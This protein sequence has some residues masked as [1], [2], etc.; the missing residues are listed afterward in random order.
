MNISETERQAR[1]Q[2]IESIKE[3]LNLEGV[4]KEHRL[5][6]SFIMEA[7]GLPMADSIPQEVKYTPIDNIFDMVRDMPPVEICRQ[8]S[9][10]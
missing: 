4:L 2:K 10:S 7:N 9:R 6:W 1:L 5:H 8:D 3:T